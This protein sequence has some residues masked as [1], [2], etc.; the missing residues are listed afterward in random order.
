MHYRSTDELI[1]SLQQLLVITMDAQELYWHRAQVTVEPNVYGISFEFQ[2][3]NK[4][5]DGVVGIDDV[6]LLSGE[7]FKHGELAG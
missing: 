6:V 5:P 4:P 2:Y 7:C 1:I 3:E